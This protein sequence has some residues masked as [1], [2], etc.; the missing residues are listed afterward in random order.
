MVL[1]H[2]W[3][4]N[5]SVW[6]HQLA[7][8]RACG[9]E[10]HTVNSCELA[11]N[12]SSTTSAGPGAGGRVRGFGALLNELGLSRAHV[13][14]HGLG[15]LAAWDIAMQEPERVRSLTTLGVGH[16]RQILYDLT[17]GSSSAYAWMLPLLLGKRAHSWY[18]LQGARHLRKLL[19]SHPDAP[20]VVERILTPAGGGGGDGDGSV[21]HGSDGWFKG[22]LSFCA[23]GIERPRV[24]V[25]TLAIRGHDDCLLPEGQLLRSG[26]DVIGHWRFCRVGGGHWTPL[27]SAGQVNQLLGEWIVHGEWST[28]CY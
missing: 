6:R 4:D 8:L 1:L 24:A 3:P 18:T 28:R 14:A 10:A 16:S 22:L 21:W 5:A 11:R 25:P 19:H 7:Y 15:A 27:E 17:S 12:A 2:G 23:G 13:V 20:A 9:I 26:L